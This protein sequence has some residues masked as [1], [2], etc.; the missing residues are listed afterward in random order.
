ME[1][2]SRI[3]GNKLPYSEIT[4]SVSTPDEYSAVHLYVADADRLEI[5][6]EEIIKTARQ[7]REAQVAK[8]VA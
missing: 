4:I 2:K 3:I 7:L 1:A 6:G 8:G 5:V